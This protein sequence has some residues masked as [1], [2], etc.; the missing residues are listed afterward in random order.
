[1][2]N[3][4]YIYNKLRNKENVYLYEDWRDVV[5]KLL[6]KNDNCVCFAKYKNKSEF[7]I[8]YS[9]KTV[10]DARLGGKIINQ[11]AYDNF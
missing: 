7:E 5:V 1:M 11:E 2:S 3:T 9:T 6:P 4:D 8:D 10:A